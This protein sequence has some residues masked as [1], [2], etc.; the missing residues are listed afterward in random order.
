MEPSQFWLSAM[1]ALI[2]FALGSLAGIWRYRQ[3]AV[4][5]VGDFTAKLTAKLIQVVAGGVSVYVGLGVKD[6]TEK[7]K[8]LGAALAGLVAVLLWEVVSLWIDSL[9]KASDRADK[10]A[11]AE[12]GRQSDARTELLAVFRQ[13]VHDKVRRLMRV[14]HRR[15]RPSVTRIRTA[16]T[17]VTHLEDLLLK[18][19]IYFS[20][21]EHDEPSVTRNF[22]VG[23]YAVRGEVIEPV[24]AVN[25]NNPNFDVFTSY[26][27][28]RQ[29]FRLD[30]TDRPSHITRC[31]RQRRTLIVEDC[32]T[33]AAAG[34][35]AFFHDDQRGYLR[36]MVTYY[37]DGICG[38]DGIMMLGALVV[39][40]DAA[41][42]F[43]ESD[44][45]SLEFCLREFGSRVKLELMLFA[46][47]T[48]Q[49]T[50]DED[51]NRGRE[52]PEAV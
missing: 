33:A 24:Y 49:D 34:E 14:A 15:G 32:E 20:A 43:R 50:L 4:K 1:G 46:L 40:T 21:R 35:F 11:L 18:L 26:R 13:A 52:G 41:G 3:D 2:L 31:I 7:E 30:E 25:L 10:A 36:S 45:D 22:R 19:A 29:A 42:F 48:N 12:L 16:L 37:L 38:K 27:R 5:L 17:P 28:H 8:W 23:L 6:T 51:S 44:R 47:L 9:A 39:D